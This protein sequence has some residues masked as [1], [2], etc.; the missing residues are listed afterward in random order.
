MNVLTGQH[1]SA[2]PPSSPTPCH[3]SRRPLSSQRG[4]A[5]YLDLAVARRRCSGTRREKARETGGKRERKRSSSQVRAKGVRVSS[6]DVTL[7]EFSVIPQLFKGR[8]SLRYLPLSNF[9]V[10]SCFCHLCEK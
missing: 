8:C 10:C 4:L 2:L 3:D 7:F 5:I 6:R 9:D 1:L